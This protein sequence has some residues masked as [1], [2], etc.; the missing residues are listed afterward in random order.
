MTRILMMRPRQNI[1]FNFWTQVTWCLCGIAC[2]RNIIS[3]VYRRPIIYGYDNVEKEMLLILRGK[4]NYG[5]CNTDSN[6]IFVYWVRIETMMLKEN[7]FI[8]IT[9][10]TI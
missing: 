3:A 6:K 9:F 8:F 4:K 10:T 5:A 2:Y 7:V 1:A